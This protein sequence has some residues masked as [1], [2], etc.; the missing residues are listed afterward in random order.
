MARL[1]TTE[2]DMPKMSTV[3]ID[4]MNKHMDYHYFVT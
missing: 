2:I 4:E 3:T 1:A